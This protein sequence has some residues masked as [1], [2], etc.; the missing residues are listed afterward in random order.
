LF[1][2]LALDLAVKLDFPLYSHTYAFSLIDPFLF[3]S[4]LVSISVHGLVVSK[5]DC[6]H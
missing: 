3:H 4:S 2:H 6:R 1:V 5:Q